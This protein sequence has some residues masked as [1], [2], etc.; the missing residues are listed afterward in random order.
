M[1]AVNA[2]PDFHTDRHPFEL[3]KQGPIV[4]RDV[5]GED[6]LVVLRDGFAAE[7]PAALI[8]SGGRWPALVTLSSRAS[9]SI[10]THKIVARSLSSVTLIRRA[11]VGNG[12]NVAAY[13]GLPA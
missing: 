3:L 9:T 7:G 2:G 6:D 12:E 1:T 13:A 5:G 4:D 8:T 11:R 10:T